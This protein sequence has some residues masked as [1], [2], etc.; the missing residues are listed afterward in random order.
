ML[1][2]HR[3]LSDGLPQQ[4]AKLD[5]FGPLSGEYTSVFNLTGI[6]T[7]VSDRSVEMDI[8]FKTAS[9]TVAERNTMTRSNRRNL[10]NT[11]SRRKT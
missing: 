10:R 9:Q 3:I 2:C 11:T 8:A 5:E 1:K 4:Y 7:T 6:P